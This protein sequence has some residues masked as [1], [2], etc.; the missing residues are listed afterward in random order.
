MWPH[1]V[2]DKMG[3]CLYTNDYYAIRVALYMLVAGSR[4]SVWTVKFMST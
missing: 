2:S 4:Q 1:R 3:H